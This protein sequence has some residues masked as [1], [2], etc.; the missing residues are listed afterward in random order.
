ME[1]TKPI[2]W[3]DFEK[4]EI[5]TGTIVAAYAFPQARKPSYKLTIDF[6]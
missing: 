5:R 1:M 6:G 2:T 4:I 3:D